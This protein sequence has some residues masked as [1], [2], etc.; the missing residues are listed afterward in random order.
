MTTAEL[1]CS[2]ESPSSLPVLSVPRTSFVDFGSLLNKLEKLEYEMCRTGETCLANSLFND[3]GSIVCTPSELD[4]LASRMKK[5]REGLSIK[6]SNEG[7]STSTQID[8]EE[9]DSKVI[10]ELDPTVYLREDGTVDWDGALQGGEAAKKFGAAVWSRINGRD[11]D[12]LNEEGKGKE[13]EVRF[14]RRERH[15]LYFYSSNERSPFALFEET[16]GR[17]RKD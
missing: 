5:A 15:V 12:E 17:G 10:K 9:E 13:E 16:K 1:L 7:E 2:L 11:P 8:E 6:I 4:E 3:M 14:R